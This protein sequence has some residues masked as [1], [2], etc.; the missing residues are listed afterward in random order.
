MRHFEGTKRWSLFPGDDST[1]AALGATLFEGSL[2]P[3][4][5]R[6]AAPFL[7][8]LQV[9]DFGDGASTSSHATTHSDN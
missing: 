5:D 2:D 3:I 7:R 1:C 6:A 8:Q 4:F 9:Q